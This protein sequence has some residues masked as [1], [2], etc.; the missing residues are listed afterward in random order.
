MPPTSRSLDVYADPT[1]RED[2]KRAALGEVADAMERVL[3]AQEPL[4][5]HPNRGIRAKIIE[6]LG[7]DEAK[8]FEAFRKA[9]LGSVPDD[10]ARPAR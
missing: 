8:Y 10:R 2:Q 3:R 4:K 7:G 9:G 1:G 6:Q 5:E